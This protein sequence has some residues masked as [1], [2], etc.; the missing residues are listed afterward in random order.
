MEKRLEHNGACMAYSVEGSGPD[1]I[2]MHGWGCD[3]STVRSITDIAA[4][5]HRV[6]TVDFP[7]HGASPEPPLRPDGTPWGVEDFTA[8]I[9]RLV[10]VEGV[11]NP[12]LIGHSF[13]G[14]VGILYASRHADVDRLVLV[15]SAGV[16]PRRPLGYYWRVYSFKAAKWL[17][18]TFLGKERGG[19]RIEAMRARR[20]SADYNRATPM[21]RSILSRVVNE[22]LTG[23]MPS[24]KAPTLLLWGEDDTATPV[25]DARRMDALI[26]DTGLV[27]FPR[28][29]HYSFLDNPAAFGR[30][31]RSFIDKS[32]VE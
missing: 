19:R 5:R 21:M 9:E 25:A 2:V 32:P 14:R 28:C 23:V 20:G 15:D 8:M 31:L 29:G 12:I 18:L 10:A 1:V 24:I 7:G 26:P 27:I 4:A 11:E 30:V 22:D 6:I 13:G 17:A 16:K 3:R